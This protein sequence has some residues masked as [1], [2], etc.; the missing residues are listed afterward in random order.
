MARELKGAKDFVGYRRKD[1]RIWDPCMIY[2]HTLVRENILAGPQWATCQGSISHL[3]WHPCGKV[4]RLAFKLARN[5]YGEN[6]S[7]VVI[8]NLQFTQ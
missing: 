3:T 1:F 5:S 2:G 7:V 6:A 4:L 8:F